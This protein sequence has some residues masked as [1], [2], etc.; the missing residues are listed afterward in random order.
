MG[1]LEKARAAVASAEAD[2]EAAEQERHKFALQLGNAVALA[3]R[4]PSADADAKVI[5]LRATVAR[6][7]GRLPRQGADFGN[8]RLGRRVLTAREYYAHLLGVKERMLV[9]LSAAEAVERR[10]SGRLPGV[11]GALSAVYNDI[12]A[13]GRSGAVSALTD[14]R[15]ALEPDRVAL[16]SLPRLRKALADLGD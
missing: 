2:I 9:E 15:N 7:E 12:L 11:L 14:L 13:G 6:L 16:D 10:W 5:A 3:E 1:E 8:N 4:E